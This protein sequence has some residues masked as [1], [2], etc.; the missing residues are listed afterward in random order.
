[1]ADAYGDEPNLTGWTMDYI[2]VT[3]E[4]RVASPDLA[5]SRP[6]DD[7]PTF[8]PSDHYGLTATIEIG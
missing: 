1:M 3:A 6:G 4:I 5:F 8:Y 7:D 2:F